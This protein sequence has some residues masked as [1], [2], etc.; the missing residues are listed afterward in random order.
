MT[1]LGLYEDI[2][3]EPSKGAILYGEP[4]T[5]K[6]LFL[7]L[8]SVLGLAL[9]NLAHQHEIHIFII[10]GSLVEATNAHTLKKEKYLTNRQLVEYDRKQAVTTVG[11]GDGKP[12]ENAA[13]D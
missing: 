12:T 11:Y 9:S 2:G 3:I 4:G 7:L 1:Q 6:T 8:L 13:R 5:S 10:S